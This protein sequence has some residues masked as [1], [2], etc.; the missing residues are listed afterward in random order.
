MDNL[1]ETTLKP[2]F[3]VIRMLFSSG[4]LLI[5]ALM[6]IGIIITEFTVPSAVT[7]I[8]IVGIVI[9][10]LMMM[11]KLF[12]YKA[13]EYIL[14]NEKINFK[15]GF[16]NNKATSIKIQNIKEIHLTQS[17]IQRLCSLGSIRILTTGSSGLS[18]GGLVLDDID[19]SDCIYMQINQ[20]IKNSLD[21]KGFA[22]QENSK[23]IKYKPEINTP[24]ILLIA[25][26]EALMVSI[27]TFGVTFG[28]CMAFSTE[29]YKTML[30]S[31]ISGVI[32]FIF[33][34]LICRFLI[35][36]E[37]DCRSYL[38]HSAKVESRAGFF[39]Y[40]YTTIYFKNIREIRLERGYFQRL[41][42]LG[43]VKIT[44]PTKNIQSQQD[45]QND[46]T[47]ILQTLFI[48][49]Q[50][51]S[52]QMSYYETGI[53]MINLKEYSKVYKIL[54][55]LILY[56]ETGKAHDKANDVP[57]ATYKP[58]F[59]LFLNLL[60]YS[61]LIFFLLLLSPIFIMGFIISK[62]MPTALL[63]ESLLIFCGYII[64]VWLQKKNYDCTKYEIYP[65]RIEFHEGFI[66]N[67]TSSILIKNIKEIHFKE[68]FIQKLFKLGTIGVITSGS[69]DSI[70]M[71]NSGEAFRDI[72]NG[73][74]IYD[75]LKQLLDEVKSN[76]VKLNEEIQKS[77]NPI[78]QEKIDKVEQV[79]I[80]Q[81]VNPNTS[82][83]IPAIKP[84]ISMFNLFINYFCMIFTI[85]VL[86]GLY[87]ILDNGTS[88]H[89]I[90]ITF[91]AIIIGLIVI[92]ILSIITT[93][94]VSIVVGINY[95]YTKYEF[96]KD[97]INFSEGFINNNYTSIEYKNIRELR[98]EQNLAQR[99]CNLGTIRVFTSADT[100]FSGLPLKDIK[101]PSE[102]YEKIKRN[103]KS[104]FM[105]ENSFKHNLIRS[106]GPKFSFIY[107]LLCYVTVGVFIVGI[108]AP[109]FILLAPFVILI[110]AFIVHKCTKYTIYTDDIEFDFKFINKKKTTVFN[111]K[112]REIHFTQGF[113]QRMFGIGT[114]KL[115]T[116]FSGGKGSTMFNVKDTNQLN[117]LLQNIANKNN[118]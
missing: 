31:S 29:L 72:E 50:K 35:R 34:T 84:K 57:K 101:N 4:A 25:I 36:L 80:S 66:I 13:T 52:Q 106:F 30:I 1:K 6:L 58:K 23:F 118:N 111:E 94:L 3:N 69:T 55:E 102:I 98:F 16:I 38:I 54:K 82:V 65:S 46:L 42:S 75:K 77:Q 109:L 88:D 10:A 110:G 90:H 17:F 96:L 51:Q 104:T 9:I 22:V 32:A 27:I 108:F 113:L 59:R 116:S 5:F 89:P 78:S 97:K 74:R 85:C 68:T 11:S 103:V 18:G 56:S 79:N 107:S 62:N 40:H 83:D 24:Y 28:V 99:I 64:P 86:T 8:I 60:R 114:F 7:G 112:L 92:S 93:I 37:Y 21:T 117:E 43:S 41:F 70:S 39:N 47:S 33:I 105:D 12:N 71:N 48:G 76:D 115:V 53:K 26:F 49:N 14:S 19:N 44:T 95:H 73:R 61:Y 91:G 20:M 63:I 100:S 67:K 15:E 45:N 87:F 81:T 2:R